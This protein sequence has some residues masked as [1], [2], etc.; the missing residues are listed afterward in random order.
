MT[1][2]GGDAAGR[3]EP[4]LEI[5][6][7]QANILAGF[8]KDH[9]VLV[10][11][12]IRG[13][14]AARAWLRRIAPEIASTAEVLA[15]NHLFR[16]LRARRGGDPQGLA[17]TWVNIVFSFDGLRQLTSEAELSGFPDDEG[18][19]RSGLF[20][21]SG[22]LSDPADPAA[23][24]N[25]ARWIVGG[26]GK[27]PDILLIVASDDPDYLTAAV[28]RLRPDPPP[29][30][31]PAADGP[32]EVIYLERGDTRP[33]LPG[34]EH[35]GF[36]DGISQPGVRGRTAEA[37][38]A[39]LTPRW[40]DPSDPQAGN[41]GR[42]GQPLIWPGHF[43]FGYPSQSRANGTVLDP[44]P[45][46]PAWV[47]NGSFLVFRRLRQDV[48][49]F[50]SFLRS[51]AADL[52]E[53]PGF[54]AITPALLGAILVG[55]WPSGAPVMRAPA[56]DDEALAANDAANNHFLYEQDT[57]P[58]HLRPGIGK[59]P[60][61]FPQAV[62]DFLGTV[63]PQA[64]HLR[65]TNP[66]DEVT[67]LGNEFDTLTRRILRRGIPF[68]PPLPEPEPPGDDGNRGLHFLSYQT[69][70]AEQFERLVEHWCNSTNQPRDGGEDPIIGQGIN[71]AGA[72]ERTLTL[73]PRNPME[74]PG[75]GPVTLTLT[76][77][78]IIPT[79]GGYF[80][81]PSLSALRDRLARS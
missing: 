49:A 80:F 34:H 28:E 31:G 46:S 38:D 42:P 62:G 12:S 67:D 55:R 6:D 70:I 59:D 57:Q 15:F 10:G 72:R 63:C 43:V 68:G 26:P 44:P 3:P 18:A 81:A 7:I 76:R 47:R 4:L 24:G 50:R 75:A 61:D 5:D 29:D 71:L 56:R 22:I 1:L 39:F 41:F 69:S 78:W 23:E 11:L 40:L 64:A 53:Q 52:S 79:G 37:P 21:R 54:A 66:R 20:R 27:V 48:A 74:P 36:K 73:K 2:P 17:A 32:P 45:L 35:F 33:D 13:V 51:A 25:P 58:V 19:F 14:E 60:G 9:Q 77:E 30:S 8:N 65:K 16:S